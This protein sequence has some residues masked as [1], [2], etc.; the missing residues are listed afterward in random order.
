VKQ[1]VDLITDYRDHMAARNKDEIIPIINNV[2]LKGIAT[3]KA[4]T[5]SG[6]SNAVEI[7][8]QIDYINEKIQK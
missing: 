5:K 6:S 4:A 7:Q 3:Q 8:K 1:G 2:I